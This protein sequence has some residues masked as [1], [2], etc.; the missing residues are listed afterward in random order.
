MNNGL[1]T[2]IGG[3]NVDLTAVLKAP[4]VQNDSIPGHVSLGM[5]GVARNMAHNLVLMGHEVRFVTLF[6]G[7]MLGQLCRDRC[8]ACGMD[9]S[10]SET[11]DDM[12]GG[13]YLCINDQQGE[14]MVAVADT[15]IIDLITP[16][17]LAA[18]LDDLNQ[19]A[20]VVAD[21]NL[22]EASL[23]YLLDHCTAPLM[24]DAVS[25]TK[26]SRIVEALQRSAC[27]RL[28]TL[29]LNLK[30]ALAVTHCETAS[31][32][33]TALTVLG[34]E[35]VY[36]TL[37]AGGVFCCSG[38]TQI[39]YPATAVD[40]VNTTGAGDAFL[41]GVAHAFVRQAPFPRTALY[42]QEAARVTLLTTEAVNPDIAKIVL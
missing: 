39:H 40:V 33:A 25:T 2:V 16:E 17:F 3:A 22:S 14:M 11:R 42:G 1:I 4:F 26:A 10:L 41:A 27:H 8:Q 28:H 19:S 23:C 35:H 31:A 18:R 15:D 30:E 5:G 13:L 38:D 20:A 29:K 12:V 34:V 21:A 6:G 32:A 36:I 37:G 9:L 24:V 7:D